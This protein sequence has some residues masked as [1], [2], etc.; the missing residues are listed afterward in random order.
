M[1]DTAGITVHVYNHGM[2]PTNVWVSERPPADQL[3]IPHIS[4]SVPLALLPCSWHVTTVS[5]PRQL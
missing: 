2:Y 4:T 1:A 3:L 5:R